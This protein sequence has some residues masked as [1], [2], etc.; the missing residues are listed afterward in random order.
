MYYVTRSVMNIP[1]I[2]CAPEKGRANICSR[3]YIY[4]SV[5]MAKMANRKHR[6]IFFYSIR[7]DC[8]LKL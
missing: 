3:M 7:D 2:N 6:E 4:D 1:P 8:I 5:A